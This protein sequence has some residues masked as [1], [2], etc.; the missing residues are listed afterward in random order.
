MASQSYG[1]LCVGQAGQIIN[2]GPSEHAPARLKGVDNA[3]NQHYPSRNLG[4][5]R[6][7][8]DL[9]ALQPVPITGFTTGV[10]V[11]FDEGKE[12]SSPVFRDS[13]RTA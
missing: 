12:Q 2:L 11:R 3:I 9:N 1:L 10:N 8:T 13:Q 4:Q 6:V 5:I 7:I